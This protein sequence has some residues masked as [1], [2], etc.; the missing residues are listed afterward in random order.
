[1]FLIINNKNRLFITNTY[2]CAFFVCFNHKKNVNN[3]SKNK[4]E[5]N[6]FSLL[7]YRKH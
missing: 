6:W 3:T 5:K 1:M 7:F 2:K 4:Y